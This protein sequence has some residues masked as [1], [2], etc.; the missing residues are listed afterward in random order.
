MLIAGL[1]S[2]ADWEQY[3]NISI[4]T[5][6]PRNNPSNDVPL[7]IID[8]IP[9]SIPPMKRESFESTTS[10]RETFD[11]LNSLEDETINK[12]FG[13][14]YFSSYNVLEISLTEYGDY[15]L[16]YDHE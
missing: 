16:T 6:A 12:T 14:W 15:T 11:W 9:D 4:I 13:T 1:E 10:S 5:G 3:G 8:D 2:G 7:A